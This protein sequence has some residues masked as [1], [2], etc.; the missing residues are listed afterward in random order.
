MS[1]H[2]NED[3]DL[4]DY[5]RADLSED[6][7]ANIDEKDDDSRE[8]CGCGDCPECNERADLEF[9]DPGGNSALRA[10]TPGNPRNL[11]CPNC[12][13]PNR[14][15]PKDVALGYQCDRCADAAEHG[16]Y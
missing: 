12:G 15:T 16:G 7:D 3:M 13:K 6:A 5:A 4:D 2:D 1:I 10:A 11:P 8:T 9:A 14:L